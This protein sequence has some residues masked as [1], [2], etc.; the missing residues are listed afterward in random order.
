MQCLLCYPFFFR[1]QKKNSVLFTGVF[2]KTSTKSQPGWEGISTETTVQLSKNKSP[3]LGFTTFSALQLIKKQGKTWNSKTPALSICGSIYVLWWFYKNPPTPTIQHKEN[4]KIPL[5]PFHNSSFETLIVM[6]PSRSFPSGLGDTL[7]SMSSHKSS[8]PTPHWELVSYHKEHGY[9]LA[10]QSERCS[11]LTGMTQ[12]CL[13][14]QISPCL[15][16]FLVPT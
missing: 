1:I 5:H 12:T 13:E 2:F 14:V 3:L 9:L 6:S 7:S 4:V 8:L 11:P 10:T 15:P 16:L